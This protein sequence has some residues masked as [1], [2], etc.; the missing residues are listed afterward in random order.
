MNN[1]KIK[2]IFF[3]QSIL[4]FHN[5]VLPLSYWITENGYGAYCVGDLPDGAYNPN[6]CILVPARPTISAVWDV[7][8]GA[9]IETLENKKSSLRVE[10]DAELARIDQYMISDVFNLLSREAQKAIVAYRQALREAPNNDDINTLSMPNPLSD[11]LFLLQEPIILPEFQNM[12]KTITKILT[13]AQIKQ[14]HKTPIKLIEAQG[15]NTIINITSCVARMMYGGSNTFVAKGKQTLRLGYENTTGLVLITTVLSNNAI[16]ASSNQIARTISD[17]QTGG[18]VLNEI[19]LP[20]VIYN[21]VATEIS[22]NAA[23][24]N[25]I[26]VVL[27]YQILDV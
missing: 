25:S 9:W 4:L 19:N 3:I 15:Q 23:N 5:F 24:D 16:V 18:P 22:G 20:V 21:P 14:L 13:S 1:K 8:H 6:S 17:A 10:R 12:T 26:I 7:E 11:E 2:F 27:T